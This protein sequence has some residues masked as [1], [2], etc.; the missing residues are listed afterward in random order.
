MWSPSSSERIKHGGARICVLS[1]RQP[2]QHGQTR[3]EHRWYWI[4]FW[5]HSRQTME[6]HVSSTGLSNRRRQ[7][8][9]LSFSVKVE[10][11]Q[12][13]SRS[14]GGRND[15][16]A[17]FFKWWT[18]DFED[19]PGGLPAFMTFLC[20]LPPDKYWKCWQTWYNYHCVYFLFITELWP[21]LPNNHSLCVVTKSLQWHCGSS[22]HFLHELCMLSWWQRN[23]G[24]N[25]G[26]V[27]RD[28]PGLC[29]PRS[30]GATYLCIVCRCMI[31]LFCS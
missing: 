23:R 9:Q 28:H 17:T 22:G 11:S 21:F 27:W 8:G 25:L 26:G 18:T 13:G 2:I 16:G 3:D 12:W 6:P 19:S 15:E 24:G 31:L 30:T 7:I 1:R 14:S 20:P 29:P 4:Q 5:Q 10:S